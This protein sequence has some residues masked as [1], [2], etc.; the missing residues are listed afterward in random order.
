M[1]FSLR[2]GG[3]SEFRPGILYNY[4]ICIIFLVAE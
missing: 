4:F 1:A 3:M 2:D